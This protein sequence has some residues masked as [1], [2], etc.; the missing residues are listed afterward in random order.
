M[1]AQ[2]ERFDT[3]VAALAVLRS[4]PLLIRQQGSDGLWDESAFPQLPHPGAEL[5]PGLS[6]LD[7]ETTTLVILR[8]LAKFGFLDSLLPTGDG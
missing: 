7:K 8:A 5:R 3:S 2:L 1:L 6:V 4:V